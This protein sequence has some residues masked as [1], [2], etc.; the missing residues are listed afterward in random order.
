MKEAV[1]ACC[2]V[3]VDFLVKL[4]MISTRVSAG[5]ETEV[6]KQTILSLP[7]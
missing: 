6:C 1:G 7:L 3:W 4:F 2:Q 5:I